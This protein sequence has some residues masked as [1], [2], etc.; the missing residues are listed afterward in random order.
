MLFSSPEFFLFLGVY[1]LLHLLVPCRYR[2]TLIILGSTVFYA[3]WNPLYLW[4]PYLLLALGFYGTRWMV[5]T[6]ELSSRRTR[7]W[8]TVALLLLPLA[9]VKY[10]NFIYQ[11]VLGPIVGASGRVLDIALPLGISFVTF[12]MIAYVVDVYRGRFPVV[13]RLSTLGGLVLFFPHLI[14]GPILRPHD[15]IPQLTHP[16]PATR[17][18]RVLLPYGITIF[19]VGL[20]KKLVFADQIAGVV[21]TVFDHDNPALTGLDYLLAIYGFAMQIYCDFSGYTDMAIGAA[22]ILGVRLPGNF[23]CPY[24][25]ASVAEFW[26]RW[27]ITLSRWLRDYLYIPL[28]GNRH[29]SRREA[30]NL[31]VTMGLG[32]LWHGANWTFVLWGLFH[33]IG[34]AATHLLRHLGGATLINALPR[35]VAVLGTFHFVCIGWIIFRARDLETAVRVFRGPFVAPGASIINFADVHV[36]AIALLLIFF[37]THRWD[38]HRAIRKFVSAAPPAVLVPALIFIWVVSIAV[39]A[40]NSGKFIY[41]DF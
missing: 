10:T 5:A 29:G 15:L 1:F 11:D 18:L 38:H 4:V 21:E 23:T 24:T 2:I 41:F 40:G 31:F 12:T 34:I 14:A 17:W 28:G 13:Q 20:L 33:G 22:L 26:R 27:H 19:S 7:L 32:G 37:A 39:S 36:F 3:F 9:V 25:A 6:D 16:R 35:W 30:V 8:A